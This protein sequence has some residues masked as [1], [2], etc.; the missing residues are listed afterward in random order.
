MHG[1]NIIQKWLREGEGPQL[2]FK[3]TIKSA[4]KIARSIVAF[5]NAR[6]G[7]IVVGIEDHGH[8]VGVNIDEEEYELR[9]AAAQFCT[10][11][12]SLSFEDYETSR[13]KMLLLVYV[14]ESV[15]K[16]HYAIDKKGREKLYVRIADACVVP[17]DTIKQ[18]LIRGDLNNLQRNHAY[19]R[20]R[21]ELIKYLNR[22]QKI[23]VSDYM[24]LYHCNERNAIRS[25]IDFM[26][27]G[28]LSPTT[29]PHQF[30]QGKNRLI[31]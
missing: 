8:V 15:T 20:R 26:F 6:G 22:H 17:N 11:P 19:A 12:I 25:L 31:R 2:D 14:D 1:R 29:K 23:S 5:A 18:T 4:A 21:N 10:P 13:G 30:R 7:L 28:V 3:Q 27:E 9:K 16:P 24:K